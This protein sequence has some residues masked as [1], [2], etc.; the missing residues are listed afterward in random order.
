MTALGEYT[1]DFDYASALGQFRQL[2]HPHIVIR[3]SSSIVTPPASE[4]GEDTF[5]IEDTDSPAGSMSND[6]ST[7][8]LA[9]TLS[10]TSL[11]SHHRRRSSA[12]RPSRTSSITPSEAGE[13]LAEIDLIPCSAEELVAFVDRPAGMKRAM[14][15][16]AGLFEEIRGKVGDDAYEN[17]L[18]PLWETSR[19]KM[20][21]FK[22]LVEARKL[23]VPD[24]EAPEHETFLW[25]R[26]AG[27]V[28]WDGE[29]EDL[30]A[31]RARPGMA[32]H[33]SSG[34]FEHGRPRPPRRG[35]TLDPWK[36]EEREERTRTEEED[37]QCK[38]VKELKEREKW[39][40]PV[41]LFFN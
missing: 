11:S 32:V 25:K 10:K 19:E 12:S 31:S 38:F 24:L 29:D 22:W 21:D 17:K 23:L 34:R 33:S 14:G 26:L 9:H 39:D 30:D 5:A 6:N 8:N 15:L 28:G 3:R 27:V 41:V 13:V 7:S 2:Q 37:L 1:T 4:H 20:V 35:S 36:E 18:L 40:E 16:H